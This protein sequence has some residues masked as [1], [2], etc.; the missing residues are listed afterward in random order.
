MSYGFGKASFEAPLND[1]FGRLRTST[2][3]SQFESKF[4]Y[5]IEDTYTTTNVNG[6]SAT[7]LSNEAAYQLATSVESGSRCVRQSNRYMQY[8]PGK[9]Q[10]IQITG[11][12]GAAKANCVKR[13]GYYDDNDG[14]FFVQD[15][16]NGF[17]VARRTSTSGTHQDTIVYQSQ[18]NLNQLS[19]LDLSKAQI[20]VIDFQWLGVGAVR[21]GFVID[22]ELVYVHQMNHANLLDKVYMKSAWLPVRYEIHNTSATASTTTMK[23]I[24]AAVSSEGGEEPIG[25]LRSA[26]RETIV[27]L[28]TSWTPV[29]SIQVSPT[30]NGQP[31]RG[32]VQ[33]RDF[34]SVVTANNPAV[35]QVI[36]KPASLTGA[37]WQPS[38]SASPVL[39]DTSATA[40]TGGEAKITTFNSSRDVSARAASGELVLYAGDIMSIVAKSVTGSSS[41]YASIDWRE[42]I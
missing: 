12:F 30:L 18:W 29:I 11:V 26:I 21:F 1:A 32:K 28:T 39:V 7:F 25:V 34:G 37:N 4:T 35:L 16:T 3:I 42:I 19:I 17:G 27:D 24:C 9:S 23:Q 10:L 38:N 22:G 31:F 14:L 8:Y 5:G 41:T 20:M 33:I 36:Y 2:P 40:F 15:G 13:I 6:G